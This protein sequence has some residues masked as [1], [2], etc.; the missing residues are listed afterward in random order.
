MHALVEIRYYYLEGDHK[1]DV[2]EKLD[3]ISQTHRLSPYTKC[4]KVRPKILYH[5]F[6]VKVTILSFEVLFIAQ[7]AKLEN[8]KG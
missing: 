4:Q 7:V 2:N 3:E 5:I 6:S 8:L 1:T